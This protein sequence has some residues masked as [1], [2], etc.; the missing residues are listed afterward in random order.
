M[1]P[2]MKESYKKCKKETRQGGNAENYVKKLYDQ[3]SAEQISDKIAEM[4]SKEGINAEVKVVYQS[5]SNLHKACPNHSGDWYFTGNYPT[6]G[7]NRVVNQAYMNFIEGK[8]I[9]PY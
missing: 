1:T 3:F 6:K 4:I 9:R 5:V 7:G 8:N 2:L